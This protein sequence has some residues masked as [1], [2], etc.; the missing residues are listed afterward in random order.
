MSRAR[1]DW[2]DSL[3]EEGTEV[4]PER[5]LLYAMLS[6]QIHSLGL[7]RRMG[8]WREDPSEMGEWI[9]EY[10][11]TNPKSKYNHQAAFLEWQLWGGATDVLIEVMER[12]TMVRI[13]RGRI[14][15]LAEK[16]AEGSWSR[17]TARTHLE[18]KQPKTKLA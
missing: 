12:E 13:D 14:V 18:G 2:M 1:M 17:G 5:R 15:K 11:Q 8:A 3:L 9:K 10:F 6:D 7:F 4:E 16:A